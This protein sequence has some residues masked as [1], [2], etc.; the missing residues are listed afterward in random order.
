MQGSQTNNVC[1]R[2]QEEVWKKIKLQGSQT[3]QEGRVNSREVWKKVKLQDSQT[4]TLVAALALWLGG[5]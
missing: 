2:R 1:I 3:M 5:E 4:S